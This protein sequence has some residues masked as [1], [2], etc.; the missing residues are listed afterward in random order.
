MQSEAKNS[1]K[2]DEESERKTTTKFRMPE[3][4]EEFRNVTCFNCDQKDHYANECSKSRQM[5]ETKSSSITTQII[6]SI[7]DQKKE[8]L[9][10][11]VLFDSIVIAAIIRSGEI[12]KK[13]VTQQTKE[14]RIVLKR[15]ERINDE[16]D[17]YLKNQERN[18]KA[19]SS[20]RNE[21]NHMTVMSEM[22]QSNEF[23][24]FDDEDEQ[25]KMMKY[26]KEKSMMM[27]Q[28]KSI[29]KKKKSANMKF[30]IV[31]RQVKK[32]MMSKELKMSNSIR[33]LRN[34]SRFNVQ[35]MMNLMMS[36]FIE[37][38]LNESQQL[39]KKFV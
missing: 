7:R 4:Y 12:K 24:E 10:K 21:S 31:K 27:S 6:L 35:K 2:N 9:T 11:C 8:N 1:I 5:R 29:S 15:N 34:R 38:L 14:K 36:L 30:K 32:L 16:H 20:N 22:N 26:S 23:H 28:R 25:A 39:R 3:S 17:R 13:K 18:E 19:D 37:Q 33:V